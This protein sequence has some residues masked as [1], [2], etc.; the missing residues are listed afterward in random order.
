M[1]L[2]IRSQDKDSLIKVE[3]IELNYDYLCC[4]DIQLIHIETDKGRVGSYSTEERALEVLDEIQNF[5][6]IE[7]HENNIDYEKA[8]LILKGRIVDSLCKIYQMPKE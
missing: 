1:E 2:W 8:D 4:N 3:K 6:R 7:I 5:I